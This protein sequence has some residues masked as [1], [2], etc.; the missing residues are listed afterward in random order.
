MS[1]NLSKW[2]SSTCFP[3]FLKLH[4]QT[5]HDGDKP[6]KCQLCPMTFPYQSSLRY[7]ITS[8]H[9]ASKSEPA[10]GTNSE[11]KS[12]GKGGY[13]CDICGKVL[14]HPSSVLYHKEAEHNDG[15]RFVCSKC[16]KAFKHK[17]LLQRHQLVHSEDR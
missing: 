10:S 15:R 11:I 1:V 6:Y 13:V 17:Q 7:H 16:G 9:D 12:D 3:F 8:Q 4:L 5:I 2:S 14:N